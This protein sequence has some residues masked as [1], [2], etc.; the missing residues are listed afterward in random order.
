MTAGSEHIRV[1]TRV[2]ICFRH[3]GINS[4][5]RLIISGTLLIKHL[6]AR[7]LRPSAMNY[8]WSA[9]E[10][11]GDARNSHVTNVTFTDH[12]Q[13]NLGALLVISPSPSRA[14][15]LP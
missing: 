2:L 11:P 13:C 6:S 14:L 5:L 1:I 9:R 15:R 8:A 3:H 10:S 7:K 4:R 12:V